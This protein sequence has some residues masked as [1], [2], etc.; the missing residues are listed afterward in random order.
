MHIKCEFRTHLQS[1][2][3]AKLV[4]GSEPVNRWFS[5]SVKRVFLKFCKTYR[6]ASMPESLFYRV[7][8][9]T[10]A[11]LWKK[12]LSHRCF[13][14]NFAKFFIATLFI[15][16]LLAAVT[17]FCKR[18]S[19]VIAQLVSEY[20]SAYEFLLEG[21]DFISLKPILFIKFYSGFLFL[22]GKLG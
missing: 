17:F 10:P 19:M 5:A 20:A 14:E 18:N 16:H 1:N 8:G 11:I 7:P 6:K 12:R 21:L 2:Y 15:E 22:D 3:S 9:V 13:P 4:N